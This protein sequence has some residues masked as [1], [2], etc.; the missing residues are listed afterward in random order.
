MGTGPPTALG[1]HVVAGTASSP[2]QH[3]T[4]PRRRKEQY[5]RLVP[6]LDMAGNRKD[7]C[8]LLSADEIS[9][10]NREIH[11]QKKN[12]YVGKARDR[13]PPRTDL[14]HRIRAKDLAQ[15]IADQ[16][17]GGELCMIP[18]CN[19][20]FLDEGREQAEYLGPNEEIE[21]T[22]GRPA[23]SDSLV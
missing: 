23:I 13:T 3:L 5:G 15:K 9:H 18:A 16:Q 10:L 2:K 17:D 22:R 6:L 12:I 19:F 21:C 8:E 20:A 11:Y 4:S 1:D 14:W 7:W